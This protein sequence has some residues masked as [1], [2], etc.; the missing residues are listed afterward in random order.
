MLC[1]SV[2]K[3]ELRDVTAFS[4]PGR[5]GAREGGLTNSR[6]TEQFDDHAPPLMKP[7]L[8]HAPNFMLDRADHLRQRLFGIHAYDAG[9]GKAEM[10]K[11]RDA[12]PD[13]HRVHIRLA[14]CGRLGRYHQL[15]DEIRRKA[16]RKSICGALKSAQPTWNHGQTCQQGTIVETEDLILRISVGD[17]DE[18]PVDSAPCGYELLSLVDGNSYSPDHQQQAVEQSRGAARALA[19]RCTFGFPPEHTHHQGHHQLERPEE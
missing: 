12:L 9:S 3:P 18:S 17:D 1:R 14:P 5:E 7:R 19:M 15:D 6:R 8:D 10:L 2:A 11:G 4:Q 16:T 13:D